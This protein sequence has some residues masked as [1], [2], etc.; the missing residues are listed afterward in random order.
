MKESPSVSVCVASHNTLSTRKN[1]LEKCLQGLNNSVAQFKK[2]FP[3]SEITISWVDDASSDNTWEYVQQH[4]TAPLTGLQ[5]KVC[6]QQGYARNLA[7]K[8]THSDLIMFCDS[9]DFFYPQHIVQSVETILQP[10]ENQKQYAAVSTTAHMSAEL[11]IHENWIPKISHTIPITKIFHRVAWEFIEGFPVNDLYK[12]TPVEDQDL[13]MLMASVFE[14]KK[15]EEETVEYICYAGS[16]FDRQLHKFQMDPTLQ[17]LSEEDQKNL[18]I[19]QARERFLNEKLE[20]LK[21]KLIHGNWHEKL[22][23]FAVKYSLG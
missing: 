9:D 16:S 3:N 22:S 15:L 6:S 10:S 4:I 17:S 14:I 1:G 19:H 23:Q 13:M 7:A 8:L 21:T 5:L 20:L 18:P 12:I 2:T 11:K